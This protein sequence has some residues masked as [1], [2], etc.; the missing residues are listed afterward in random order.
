MYPRLTKVAATLLA[1]A[2]LLATTAYGEDLPSVEEIVAKY[3]EALGGKDAVEKISN[4]IEH[5]QVSVP[6]MATKGPYT[7]YIEPPNHHNLSNFAGMGIVQNGLTD[8]VEWTLNPLLG[9]KAAKTDNIAFLN[10][11][12][13]WEERF[14]SAQ[15][16]GEET[17][18]EQVYY[19]VVFT[20]ADEEP[21]IMLFH[22]STGLLYSVATPLPG[23]R[24][25]T[26]TYTDYKDVGGILAPHGWT[27]TGGPF[28]VEIVLETIELDGEIPEGQFDLP[29]VVQA[30]LDKA[31]E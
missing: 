3:F 11:L 24:A 12:F 6:Q 19:K 7:A 2:I 21:T 14:A 5:G 20:P 27:L 15:C 25:E 13:G 16:T 10:Q 30:I 31:E 1:C 4:R 9:N 18:E 17:V 8:G 23:G 22:K 29:E 26:R 28:T